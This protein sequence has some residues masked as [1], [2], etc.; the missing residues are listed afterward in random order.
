MNALTR[1]IGML[2]AVVVALGIS[3][4]PIHACA[5]CFGAADSPQTHA[6]NAAIITML[7]VTYTLFLAMAATAFFLWRRALAGTVDVASDGA[8][9]DDVDHG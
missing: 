1:T 9:E 7:G 4:A 5:T 3:T 8:G 6:M 2:A